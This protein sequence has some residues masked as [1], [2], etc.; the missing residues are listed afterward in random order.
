LKTAAALIIGNELLSGKISEAN[1]PLLARALRA[2]GI[3]LR[4]VVMVL[5]EVDTIAAEVA[6]LSRAHDWVFTSGGVGPTHDDVTIESV[7]K[8][9]GVPVVSSPLLESMLRS[10]YQ[11]RR[12]RVTD[13]HL[14]MALIPEGASLETTATITWPTVR[15]QNV[16]VMPGVPEVFKMK[17]SVVSEKLAGQGGPAFVS[18]AVYTKMDEGDLKPLLDRV[19]ASHPEVDVGS[20]PKWLDPTYKTK[21]T[22][23]GRDE[24]RVL[25]ARDAFVALLPK[26]EPQKV[27]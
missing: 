12:E 27:E 14:R 22:F 2:L 25:A 5:D 9:F 10:H 3:Q 21:L 8:A 15:M 19:V 4:R 18:R 23:D 20:Y 6:A 11:A 13:G 17:L 16:W 26:G 24:A 7:A 1:L